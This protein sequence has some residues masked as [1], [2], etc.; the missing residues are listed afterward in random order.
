[1]EIDGGLGEPHE[2]HA[3]HDEP[4]GAGAHSLAEG[5]GLLGR[6]QAGARGCPC[7]GLG[8]WSA[9]VRVEAEVLR[10]S[11]DEE[12]RGNG[13]AQEAHAGQSGVGVP[14]TGGDDD[15]VDDQGQRRL[16]C[17]ESDTGEGR[18]PAPLVDEPVGDGDGDAG[19]DTRDGHAAPDAEEGPEVPRLGHGS[20]AEHTSGDEHAGD[21]HWGPGAA[22]VQE[23][24]DGGGEDGAGEATGGEGQGYGGAGPAELVT[25]GPYEDGEDGAEHGG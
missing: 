2:G 16:A 5:P 7:N 6:A 10:P 24:A 3:E 20:Q 19:L 13:D 18:G 12:G 11:P 25:D 15:G 1:M 4:E 14:P 23:H 17:A 9:A 22:A 8:V 21:D